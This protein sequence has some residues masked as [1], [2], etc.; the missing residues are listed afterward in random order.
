MYYFISLHNIWVFNDF[1]GNDS[2][3]GEDEIN[4]DFISGSTSSIIRV[5]SFNW[6]KVLFNIFVNLIK[7]NFVEEVTY[8]P[9]IQEN[10]V[11]VNIC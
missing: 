1:K 9:F 3:S 10:F 2:D 4:D 6:P 5:I 7:S 11:K 8:A